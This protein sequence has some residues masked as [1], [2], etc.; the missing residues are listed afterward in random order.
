MKLIY[1]VCIV[2]TVVVLSNALHEEIHVY[3]FA[4]HNVTPDEV[5]YFGHDEGAV[6]WVLPNENVEDTRYWELQAYSIQAVFVIVMMFIIS[7]FTD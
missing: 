7:R 3:Q 5:C 4:Q 1:F 2:F 6:G